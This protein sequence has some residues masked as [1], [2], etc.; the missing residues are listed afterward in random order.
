MASWSR[1][2]TGW[3][4]EWSRDF[5]NRISP[6]IALLKKCDND[7]SNSLKELKDDAKVIEECEYACVCEG[8]DGLTEAF[9]TGNEVLARLN[10]RITI[11]LQKREQIALQAMRTAIQKIYC[12][13]HHLF[14]LLEMW[15][16]VTLNNHQYDFLSCS[17]L[18]S[19][20]LY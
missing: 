1:N 18:I 15:V 7:W 19:M 13:Q 4:R 3:R 16:L 8:E 2:C 10:A 20:A 9:L 17:C 12:C 14:N 11:I 6:N 5:A